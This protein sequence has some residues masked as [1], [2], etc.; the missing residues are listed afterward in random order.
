MAL[1]DKQKIFANEY[2]KDLNATRAYK[3]AYPACKKDESASTAGARMLRNVKVAAY[4]EKR[5]R[6]RERR[7]EI[8]Q[9]KVINELALIAFSK[10]TDYAKVVECTLETEIDGVRK[11]VIS[12]DGSPIVYRDIQFALTS[13]LNEDQKKP[14]SLIKKGREGLE[15]RLYD[16][17]RA[18]ELLGKHLGMWTDK[19]EISKSIDET[20]L[21][22]EDYLCEKKKEDT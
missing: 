6:E 3:E 12:S 19:S 20:I 7:T 8:T 21:E 13:E 22:M 18:L 14:L 4:I 17:I 16:K 15:V 11:Q 9:D 1:T 10:I 5:M 2:L